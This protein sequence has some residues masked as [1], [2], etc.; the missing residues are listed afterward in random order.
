MKPLP[1]LQPQSAPPLLGIEDIGAMQDEVRALAERAQRRDPRAQLPA[2]RGA[3]RRARGRRLARALAAGRGHRRRRDRVLRRALHGRD[4]VDPLARQ[5]GADPRPRRRLLA[6][7]LDHRRPAAR[8]EGAAPGRDRR[9]V[10]EHLRRGEGR[11]RLLLHLVER[12][13]G[14]GAHLRRARRRHRGPVRARHVAG[15][16]RRARDRSRPRGLGRRVP[17]ARGHPARRHQRAARERA[18]TRTS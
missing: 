15:R 5:D 1:T 14:R 10:R 9:D 2:A 17:R 4:G 8:L 18:A 12:G 6:V 3:G 7:R 11:D 13:Q 16:V